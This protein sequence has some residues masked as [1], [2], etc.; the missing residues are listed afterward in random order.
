M[1]VTEDKADFGMEECVRGRSLEK[2]D[3]RRAVVALVDDGAA[4]VAR[5]LIGAFGNIA[6]GNMMENPVYSVGVEVLA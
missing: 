3:E 1:H 4:V 5:F 6:S 2:D